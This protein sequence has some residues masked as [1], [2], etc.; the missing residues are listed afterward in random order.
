MMFALSCLHFPEVY[1]RMISLALPPSHRV[2]RIRSAQIAQ[3][4]LR[5][6]PI[7]VAVAAIL[8][9]S[10]ATLASAQKTTLNYDKSEDFS[11]LKTYTWV[12]GT[13]VANPTLDA[14][15][16]GAVDGMLEKRGMQKAAP[17]QADVYLTYHAAS[18]ADVKAGGFED[19]SSITTGGTPQPGQTMW[20]T[21]AMGSS[22]SMV[23][24]GG[25]TFQMYDRTQH[26]MIWSSGASGTLKEKRG[27]R[28][29][30]LDKSLI[31]IFDAY[32][33]RAK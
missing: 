7:Y 16:K 1:A 18:D 20:D 19:P 24:K 12:Q 29:D 23:R 13:P 27:E 28:F 14:Y 32:P 30:Q 31:K 6:A 15:I 9:V 11:K 4:P 25:I 3:L 8:L 22:A 10:A 2:R 21:A 26:K 33:P 5:L 17:N